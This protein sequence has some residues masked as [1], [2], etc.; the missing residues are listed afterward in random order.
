M[1]VK[2]TKYAFLVHDKEFE[3]FLRDIQ[4]IGVLDITQEKTALSNE[5]KELLE[6]RNRMNAV[7]KAL[8]LRKVED[9]ENSLDAMSILLR[10]E[11]IAKENELLDNQ[12][13]KLGKEL[14]ELQ[15]WG[16]FDPTQIEELASLKGISLRYFTVPSKKYQDE[17]EL[18]YPLYKV[19]EDMGQTYFV[20]VSEG[21]SASFNLSANEVRVPQKS[22]SKLKE[23]IDELTSRKKELTNELD[24]L[25]KGRGA[26]TRFTN[27]LSDK[28]SFGS[29][30]SRTKREVGGSV[31]LMFGFAPA[32]AVDE[33]NA[34][35]SAN[36]AI[37]IAEDAKEEDNPPIKLK[38]N[39][40]AKLFEPIGELYIPPKYSELDLTPLFAPF[41]MLFFG[42]CMNDIGYGIVF[43]VAGFILRAIPKFA[44]FK[45]YIL[46]VQW[47]G[48]G[49]ILMGFISG[50]IFGTE[51]REWEI[52]PENIRHLFLNTDN[53]MIFAVLIG[54]VQIIFGLVV[55]AIN[56]ARQHGWV[57]G[58]GPFGWIFI[59]G[60]LAMLALP[61]TKGIALYTVYV[62][63]GIIL[64]FGHPH[65]NI[66]GRLGMGL[67]EL[68]EITGFFGD[69]L[70]Y[71]RLFA[72]GIAGAILG[73]VVNKIASLAIGT[74]PYGIDYVIFGII[75]VLGH[76]ANIALSSLGSF[77]HPMRLTFV[78]FYKNSGF[79]GGGKFYAPF[80]KS[81]KT[82]E[83]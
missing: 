81:N 24:E 73:M 57:A 54:F 56:R 75:I 31:A 13:R 2:M 48:L 77:V 28:L 32:N 71:I 60:G 35:L 41:F 42:L 55:K 61:Q 22:L 10:Y 51:M 64:F 63:I 39:S 46:L 16:D 66:F 79:S 20:L 67:V 7:Y 21:S 11:E 19:N 8:T 27:E 38:N 58:I 33:L 17:W 14:V 5:E 29:I 36:S 44:S 43:V 45:P 76:T 62:G 50:S 78:E 82:Q 69:L 23:S 3:S 68:Y 72:L 1:I 70:S 59:L 37:Y 15:P 80:K 6:L 40:F 26:L 12:L 83:N 65:G 25:A 74:L 30:L 47:L 49:T 18:Q 53:M 4:E 52:L 9:V 34:Y